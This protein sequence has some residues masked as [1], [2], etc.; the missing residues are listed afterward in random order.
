MKLSINYEEL[1]LIYECVKQCAADELQKQED[2][3]KFEKLEALEEKLGY[4]V[5]RV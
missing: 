4:R 2:Q 5:G 1:K 3:P